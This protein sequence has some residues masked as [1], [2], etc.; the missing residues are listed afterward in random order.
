MANYHLFLAKLENINVEIYPRLLY[1][2][3]LVLYTNLKIRCKD[4]KMTTYFA[5]STPTLS[6]PARRLCIVHLLCFR[7]LWQKE[8]I[9][10]KL[11]LKK[12]LFYIYTFFHNFFHI[13]HTCKWMRSVIIL[14]RSVI[15][16][17]PDPIFVRGV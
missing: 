10:W 9:T 8:L 12:R 3:L 13:T 14:M 15:K 1:L 5:L 6:T 17:I 11:K 7:S 4:S 16:I 2:V